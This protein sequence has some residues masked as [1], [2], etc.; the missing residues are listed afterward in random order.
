MNAISQQ[1]QD[2][3]PQF[4]QTID[5][6]SRLVLANEYYNRSVQA[7]LSVEERIK[8]RL[9]AKKI[10]LEV[11]TEAPDQVDMLNIMGRIS[12]DEM[13]FDSALV[14]LTK[15][16]KADPEMITSWINM[17]YL[18]LICRK[19]EHA[20][21]CLNH[22]L[23]LD[24]NNLR[25]QKVLAY[26]KLQHGNYIEAFQTYRALIKQGMIDETIQSGLAQAAPM[27]KADAFDPQLQSDVESFMKL[28][29]VNPEA[30]ATLAI[31]LLD[32]KYG[33][34]NEDGQLD[35]DELAN[36]HFL[37]QCLSNIQ[38]PSQSIEELARS[39]RYCVL[40]DS[41]HN[42]RIRDELV[43]L[44]VALSLYSSNNE[45]VMEVKPDE[46]QGLEALIM[47]LNGFV[48]DK[49][50]QPNDI[51]GAL[52]LVTMYQP[53]SSLGISEDISERS[54]NDWADF[55]QPIVEKSLF[56]NLYLAE[57]ASE[58]PK[59]SSKNKNANNGGSSVISEHYN[60]SPYPRWTSL[61]YHAPTDYLQA[62]HTE[63]PHFQPAHQLKGKTLEFLVAGCGTGLQAIRAAK[64]FN[65][66][67][68]TAVDL[69]PASVAYARMMA[70]KLRVD[71]VEFFEGN[72][73]DVKALG[74]TFDVIEC[75]G[76]LHHMPNPQ[77]GLQALYDV[78]ADHG[79]IKIGLYSELAR[80]QITA[81]KD[82]IE[83]NEIKP[84]LENIQ[85]FRAML[86]N[87]EIDGDYSEIVSRP[88]FYTSSGC[89]D[90][91]FNPI[92]HLYT[93][94]KVS[95]LLEQF[96]LNFLGFIGVSNQYKSQFDAAFPLDQTR[97]SL[98]NWDQIEQE[99]PQMFNCMY[100]LYCSK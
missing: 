86:M 49:T 23:K 50:W 5:G 15:A 89:R 94:P 83:T 11:L 39:L 92:E 52:V 41:L 14:L 29:E 91:L 54:I 66:I 87:K 27:I 2:K 37:L 97:S 46:Q 24:P 80:Q 77:E 33:L 44:A 79:L 51:A 48:S 88:D 67:K 84:T 43:N 17:A 26:T 18:H 70:M 72:L 73:L 21:K 10:C 63:L 55:M 53:I 4:N 96:S 22:V 65:N 13:D 30:F 9:K 1:I 20:E 25:A 81:T 58:N 36:D 68:V 12:M 47:L 100:Q 3:H 64:Y 74:K 76:V 71:N 8:E 85:Q 6:A 82:I 61:G 99:N 7:D 93:L 16:L 42:T 69:S 56:D 90:L 32:H 59:L 28:P 19:P 45:Y 78:L 35:L 57:L 98:E 34:S 40:A 60:E 75:S 62:L 31:S 95:A 38:M